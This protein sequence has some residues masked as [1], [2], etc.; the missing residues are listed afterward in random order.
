MS[1]N[2]KGKWKRRIE[3]GGVRGEALIT[4]SYTFI[5]FLNWIFPAGRRYNKDGKKQTGQGCGADRDGGVQE[6]LRENMANKWRK[7]KHGEIT[8]QKDY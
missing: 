3:Q 1:E 2:K 6:R 4:E 8:Y 5:P 7:S